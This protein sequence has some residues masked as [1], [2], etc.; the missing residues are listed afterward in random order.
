VLSLQVKRPTMLEE[1]AYSCGIKPDSMPLD[2]L[3]HD[4]ED[5]YEAVSS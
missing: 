5:P 3:L 4:V 2:K 1:L